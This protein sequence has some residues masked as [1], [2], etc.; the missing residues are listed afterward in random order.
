[1]DSG[2]SIPARTFLDCSVSESFRSHASVVVPRCVVFSIRLRR[3]FR[4]R[5]VSLSP[6]P[7]PAHRFANRSVL[8]AE[9]V[10]PFF[11]RLFVISVVEK[12][13]RTR[14]FSLSLSSLSSLKNSARLEVTDRSSNAKGYRY[15]YVFSPAG[16]EL[17]DKAYL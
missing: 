4:P 1:M 3:S 15:G 14:I 6:L 7:S 9:Q 2:S 16:G 17:N 8:V 10:R 13:P 12:F 11:S 5:G